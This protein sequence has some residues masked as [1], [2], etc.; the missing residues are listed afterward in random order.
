MM[1]SRSL[2][3]TEGLCSFGNAKVGEA[4]VG[5]AKFGEAKVGE[6]VILSLAT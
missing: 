5:E 1:C 3:D 4:K 2:H 6:T